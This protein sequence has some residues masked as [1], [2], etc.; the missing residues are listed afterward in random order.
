M[1]FRNIVSL[2]EALD[3]NYN[4]SGPVR[5][6]LFIGLIIVCIAVPYMLGSIDF[7]IIISK[8]R[9]NSDIRK[10]GSGNAGAT[11]MLRT[12]GKGAA[13][14]T[15]AGDMLK[16]VAG[17]TIG[18][19]LLSEIGA[20][21]AGLFCVLGHIFP[22]WHKFKGG[23]GVAA[24]AMVALMLSPLT[25]L[26]LLVVFL[27]I[28]ISTKYVSLA[29][30]MSVML[31]PLFLNSLEGPGIHVIIAFII[32]C[33]VVFMHRSNIKRLLDKSEPKINLKR[34]KTEGMSGILDAGEAGVNVNNNE[35][36][37]EII[38]KNTSK[39]KLKKR[40]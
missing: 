8:F 34:K 2:F 12:Y 33:L 40:K 9:Y 1:F 14:M 39:K 3:S 22:C 29:S 30:I 5:S 21:I 16:C 35:A 28:V 15:L 26:V 11:N 6:L 27:A 23:K 13:L 24:T 31:F 18:G 37:T 7:G 25:F 20:S 38:T 36:A 17:M 10:F 19:I 32:A 4:M